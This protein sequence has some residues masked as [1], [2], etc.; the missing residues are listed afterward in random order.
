[1][2][3]FGAGMGL[4]GLLQR[5]IRA[6]NG[7]VNASTSINCKANSTPI[8][9]KL[10]K[11]KPTHNKRKTP[12]PNVKLSYVI[13]GRPAL[14]LKRDMEKRGGKLSQTRLKQKQQNFAQLNS[15]K[16]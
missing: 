15:L 13:A 6:P 9:K 1:M 3:A 2:A 4:Y 14:R 10:Q 7:F 5:P 8:P 12:L 16:Y 11:T